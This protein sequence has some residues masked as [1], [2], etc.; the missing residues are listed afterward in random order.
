MTFLLAIA[1]AFLIGY[2]IAAGQEEIRQI[3]ESEPS[4]FGMQGVVNN[5]EALKGL[6]RA[7][8]RR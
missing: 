5:I 6:F 8:K 2:N 7:R 4:D 1:C 3:H